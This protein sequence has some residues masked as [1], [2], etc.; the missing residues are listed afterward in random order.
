MKLATLAASY[1]LANLYNVFICI[2]FSQVHPT[3]DSQVPT[4]NMDLAINT[5]QLGRPDNLVSNRVN[6]LHKI[7]TCTLPMGPR[8][9][10]E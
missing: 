1:V 4:V 8:E 3:P 7:V 6:F 10:R 5:T 9:K 2:F